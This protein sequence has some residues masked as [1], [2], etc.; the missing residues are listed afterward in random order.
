[1]TF[2]RGKHGLVSVLL[3]VKNGADHLADALESLLAQ[4]YE[5]FEIVAVDHSSTDSTPE[6][7][8]EFALK[9]DRLKINRFD[10]K[11][12][13]DC[14]N[15]GLSICQGEFV[16]RADADDICRNDRLKLQTA[17]LDNN[18]DIGIVGCKVKIFRE[19]GVME[20]YRRY[21]EW[22]N[23][24]LSP[25]EIEREIFVESP[26]PHPSVM[27][28]KSVVEKLGGYM[29]N[30]W[31]EDYD[32]WLRA[33]FAGIRMAK[34]PELL[35]EWRDHSARMS[36]NEKRYSRKSFHMA[37]AFYLAKLAKAA[38]DKKIVIQGA[39]TTGKV[40]GKYLKKYGAKLKAYFDINPRKIGGT[41]LGLPV[42]SP[43][44][45]HLF[46]DHMLI[47]AVSSWDARDEIRLLAQN[48]GFT[49]GVD[50]FCAS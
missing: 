33:K 37:R 21:E 40:I 34:A 11:S 7:L 43:E 22:V 10:G 36:R 35:L 28:R 1:M 42:H 48:A 31:P 30:G 27:M 18:P 49:E 50:F 24:L 45:L 17:F 14:L 16:A 3:P 25:E 26:L 8:S 9:D 20:G 39:G 41:K 32:M 19:D 6:I 38:G 47:S 23:S 13:V 44:E 5:N 2:I 15:F 29:D 46:T 12:F 4:T